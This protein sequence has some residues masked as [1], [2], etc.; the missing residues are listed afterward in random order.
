MVFLIYLFIFFNPPLLKKGDQE[1]E[2]NL[3]EKKRL[4]QVVQIEEDTWEEQRERQSVPGVFLSSDIVSSNF[5]LVSCKE[6]TL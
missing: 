1:E 4:G 2:E 5:L 3:E 6:F